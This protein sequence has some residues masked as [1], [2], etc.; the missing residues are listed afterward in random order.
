MHGVVVGEG[1][2]PGDGGGGGAEPGVV[3]GVEVPGPD[4]WPALST[5]MTE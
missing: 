5:A 1:P 2:D 4:V 3:T